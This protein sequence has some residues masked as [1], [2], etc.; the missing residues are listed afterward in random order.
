MRK[1]ELFSDEIKIV[2]KNLADILEDM[3]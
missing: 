2:K 1:V 3:K